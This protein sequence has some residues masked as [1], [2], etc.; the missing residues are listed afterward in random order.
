MSPRI[1]TITGTFTLALTLLSCGSSRG[2]SV[3]VVVPQGA[4]FASAAASLAAR[5]L[6]RTPRLF[7]L[8]ALALHRDRSI[9]AGTYSL[10][11]GTSWS[12]LLDALNNGKGLV[13]AFTIPEGF[14]LSA[15]FR[16]SRARCSC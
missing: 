16:S 15:L 14:D 6:V 10:T 2:P 7:R 8:Y 4:S 11:T 5:G 13:N 3:R 9:K 12:D 1:G